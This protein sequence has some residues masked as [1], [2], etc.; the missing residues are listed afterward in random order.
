MNQI[1]CRAAL[2]LV[3]SWLVAAP[4]GAVDPLPAP[5]SGASVLGLVVPLLAV[6]FS[7]AALWWMVRRNS[8]RTGAAGPARIVQVIAVGP[9]ERVVV[10]DHDARRFLLGVT[11]TTINVLADLDGENAAKNHAGASSNVIARVA[12]NV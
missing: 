5:S 8:G 2:F 10:I 3:S 12:G 7:L 1:N 11:A 9:R 6:A 4:A